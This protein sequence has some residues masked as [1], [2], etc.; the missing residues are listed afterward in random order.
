MCS[1]HTNDDSTYSEY[2]SEEKEHSLDGNNRYDKFKL[3]FVF[4]ILKIISLRIFSIFVYN[5]RVNTPHSEDFIHRRTRSLDSVS[6][7]HSSGSGSTLNDKDRGDSSHR[8]KI[9]VRPY[10]D[11]QEDEDH[12]CLPAYKRLINIY[13][14]Y[15]RLI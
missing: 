8:K 5:S 13:I 14:T 2:G 7:G 11:P 1:I 12:S 3:L 15:K 9:S 4:A 6:S 10:E